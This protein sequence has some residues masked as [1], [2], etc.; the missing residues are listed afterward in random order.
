MFL[1]INQASD[2]KEDVKSKPAGDK[3][4]RR[5]VIAMLMLCFAL[6]YPADG[7]AKAKKKAAETPNNKYASI[8]VDAASGAVLSEKNASKRLHPASLTKVM[9]LM[10]L[11][12]ALENGNV[13]LNDKIYISKHA[14]AQQPSG[15][16]MP[17]P[18]PTATTA[19]AMELR[20]PTMIME[21]MSRPKWSVPNQCAADMVF[22]LSATT[23]LVTS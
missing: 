5:I 16:P 23:R 6:A 13:R 10:L 12:D 11:F 17:M 9:T 8:I 15:T 19:T 4:L 18:M 21:K 2:K 3:V 22:I 14:A 20:A 7:M 1:I